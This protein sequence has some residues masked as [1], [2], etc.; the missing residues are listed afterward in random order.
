MVKDVIVDE[1]GSVDHLRDDGNHALALLGSPHHP[2]VRVESMADAHRDHWP[3][4]LP[5]P[6]KVVL[7]HL[8]QLSVN[9]EDLILKLEHLENY[10]QSYQRNYQL[11]QLLNHHVDCQSIH[12]WH[13]QLDHLSNYHMNHHWNHQWNYLQNCQWNHQCN[14]LFNL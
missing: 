7:G 6:V 5:C 3:Q 12:Q 11:D 1:G 8:T 4:S 13:N 9:L 14:H 10:H 2:S